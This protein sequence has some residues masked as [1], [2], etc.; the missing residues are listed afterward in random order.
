MAGTGFIG[1]DTMGISC[2]RCVRILCLAALYESWSVPI[3]VL[4]II[5]LGV[6]GAVSAALIAG[7]ENDVYFQVG[8]LTTMGLSAKCNSHY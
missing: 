6:L 3:A 5:P 2:L 8:I 7:F 1:T 4:L